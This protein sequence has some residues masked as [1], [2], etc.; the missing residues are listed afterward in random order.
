M[1]T[2]KFECIASYYLEDF[3]ATALRNCLK[4]V[5]LNLAHNLIEN[6]TSDMFYDWTESMEVL[7]LKGNKIKQFPS[8]LFQ[9]S[10]KIRELSLSFNPLKT[11]SVD[12][13]VDI[14]DTLES[15]EMNM[16]FEEAPFPME[17]LKSLRQL[18]WLSLEYNAIVSLPTLTLNF[19]KLQ[20][21]SL[22]GNRITALNSKIFRGAKLRSLRDVRLSHNAI[23]TLPRHSFHSLGTS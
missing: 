12:A 6:V 5:H 8:R 13:F 10:P 20:Y 9:H 18:R 16:V 21:L 3:P 14:A 23:Q 7:N 22:E 19:D 2:L 15:L 4:L 1:N 11:I 17:L